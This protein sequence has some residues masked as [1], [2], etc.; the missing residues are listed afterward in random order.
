MTAG[1]NVAGVIV[2]QH[3]GERRERRIDEIPPDELKRIAHG[4]TVRAFQAAGYK[5]L[6]GNNYEQQGN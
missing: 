2:D 4:M 3:H 6:G 1:W 5:V